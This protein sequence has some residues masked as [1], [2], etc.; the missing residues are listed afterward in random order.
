ME[1]SRTI[2]PSGL[3][4]F[5]R[6]TSWPAGP[7]YLNE[8]PLGPEEMKFAVAVAFAIGVAASDDH[9]FHMD[10]Q[11]FPVRLLRVENPSC[12]RRELANRHTLNDMNGVFRPKGPIVA[13]AAA[14][15][16]RWADMWWPFRP[17]D[18]VGNTSLVTTLLKERQIVLTLF[19]M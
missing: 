14:T 17:E 13:A 6:I 12:C 5:T 4:L 10:D 1:W 3:V 9:R 2:G 15:L 7:G 11:C 8:W 16:C 18:D 19:V